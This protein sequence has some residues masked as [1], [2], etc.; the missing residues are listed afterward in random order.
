MDLE[1][2]SVSQLESMSVSQL[3]AAITAA[4]MSFADCLEKSDLRTRAAEAV[5]HISPA[6]GTGS[7]TNKIRQR[8]VCAGCKVP[9]IAGKYLTDTNGQNHH[10]RCFVCSQCKGPFSGRYTLEDGKAT[11]MKCTEDNADKCT[12][13]GKSTATA[14]STADPE[15]SSVMYVDTMAYHPVCYTCNHCGCSLAGASVY[16]LGGEIYCKKHNSSPVKKSSSVSC[17]AAANPAKNGTHKECWACPKSK[18]KGSI[19]ICGNDHRALSSNATVSAAKEQ[20]RKREAAKKQEQQRKTAEEQE[21]GRQNAKTEEQERKR[22]A[23]KEQERQR[24]TS[25]EQE[26]RRQAADKAAKDLEQKRLLAAETKATEAAKAASSSLQPTPSPASAPSPG[27]GT[28]TQKKLSRDERRA[29]MVR[30]A[31]LEKKRQAAQDICKTDITS[32]GLLWENVRDRDIHDIVVL[33]VTV[34]RMQQNMPP[35]DEQTQPTEIG[36][37]TDTSSPEYLVELEMDFEDHDDTMFDGVETVANALGHDVKRGPNK[38]KARKEEKAKLAYGG[39]Y[40]KLKDLR[41]VSMI[42][43]NIKEINDAIIRLEAAGI[44]IC[45]VKNRFDRR[46]MAAELSAG[47]RDLQLNIRIPGTGLIWELQIHLEAIEA[48]K[49]ELCDVADESGRTGHQRYIAYRTIMERL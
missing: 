12:R 13:C 38:K 7:P 4:G 40:S 30:E 14:V 15:V 29:I 49:S 2:I 1:S 24:K 8:P 19:C 41:R 42:C 45:R 43:K 46:Y 20:E 26:Q 34:G 23:A 18:K 36:G 33:E 31:K 3:K 27:P 48:L 35:A 10:P 6:S 37:V 22:Q 39:N 11:C 28:P 16:K 47:Y 5:D 21:R 25:K 44:D 9:I 17:K 32:Y